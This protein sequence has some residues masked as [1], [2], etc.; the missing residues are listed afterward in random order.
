MP[1]ESSTATAQ[2][3]K[4]GPWGTMSPTVIAQLKPQDAREVRSFK[5]NRPQ[6]SCRIDPTGRFL[7]AGAQDAL[8]QRWDLASGDKMTFS[9]HESWVKALA[10]APGVLLSGDYAGRLMGWDYAAE[11][12]SKPLFSLEA[13]D[14]WL[15]ALAV[16]PDGKTAASVGNDQVVRLWSLTEGPPQ[17]QTKL[18][19][20]EAH[21]YNVAFS[22]DG[23]SLVTADL[24]GV[25][26]H[27]DL[28]SGRQQRQFVAKDLHKYDKTFRADIGGARGMTFSW[29]GKRLACSG[30]TNVSNAFAGIGN[31]A[32]VLFEWE[33]GE[34]T[35]LFKPAGNY[36]GVAWGV[37]LHP[38]GMVISAVGG[39]SGG[40]LCFWDPQRKDNK[41]SEPTFQFKLPTVARDQ[42]M[43]P[44]GIHLAVA[45]VDGTI[46]LYDLSS[47]K[48]QS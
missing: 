22:P 9:G 4:A 15:R 24:K 10:F 1:D 44:D 20:H 13:H 3:A 34:Q 46:R 26:K 29:D 5:H 19:G 27:W 35:H 17:L 31:P 6:L 37:D 42:S 48:P 25:I 8:L 30:I 45:L 14:G 7:F 2:E 11:D 21:I 36:R 41:K 12:F 33:T 28:P 32:V 38:G 16:S 18:L 43:H 40:S 39:S 23:Q 47:K